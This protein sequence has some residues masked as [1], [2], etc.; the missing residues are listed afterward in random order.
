M[1]TN[2][3]IE[4]TDHTFN[5]WRGCTQVAAGCEHCYAERQSKRNPGVLGIWGPRGTRVRAADAHWRLPLKWDRAAAA[6]GV[7][8]R[9]FCASLADVFEDWP[10]SVTNSDGE[11]LSRDEWGRHTTAGYPDPWTTL[12]DLRRDLFA[13]IDATPWLDW[14]LLTK[15]P[16]NVRRMWVE[17]PVP[18]SEERDSRS[19]PLAPR[20]FRPNVWLVTSIATQADADKNIPE[21]LRCRDLVSVLGVSAEPLLA[22]VDLHF[23]ACW[24]RDDCYTLGERLDW[25][26]CGGESGPHARPLHPE[27]ARSL[28]DQC[29]A[30]GVPFFFK[31][32][33]EWREGIVGPYV[34][35]RNPACLLHRSGRFLSRE[36]DL[37][38]GV[39]RSMRLDR[40]PIFVT[41]TGTPA[42]GRV[43]DGRTW[44]E[45]PAGRE[46]L[47]S[48]PP[49]C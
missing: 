24:L 32:W 49:Q 33:G 10:G 1:G 38:E 39:L 3:K 31:Q 27:W 13:L 30:T 15:R 8:Q 19:S 46:H 25:V 45:L 21:L 17:A 5:P 42:A 37:S 43:L 7:R 41:R 26:I 20:S 23:D 18:R 12:D 29:Q 36:E 11:R 16:E 4:W 6:A 44:D 28:R 40:D 14:I 9:V 35:E 47:C 2:S 48:P 22:P 34:G